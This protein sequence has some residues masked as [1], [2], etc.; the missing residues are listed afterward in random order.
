[1]KEVIAK[2]K[3]FEEK[4]GLKLYKEIMDDLNRIEMKLKDL[5]TSREAWRDKY[6][7]K[8]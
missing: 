3:K 4:S 2:I 6:Y 7:A 5:R 8:R 1:M